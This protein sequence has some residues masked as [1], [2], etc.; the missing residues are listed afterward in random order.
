M[1]LQGLL[2]LTVVSFSTAVVMAQEVPDHA[3]T[4]EEIEWLGGKVKPDKASPSQAGISV[5]LCG[6]KTFD[7]NKVHL[8]KSIKNVTW[9]DLTD[10]GITD[11]GLKELKGLKNLAL[12]GLSDTM[13]TDA[14]SS[15]SQE[16]ASYSG[17]GS[18]GMVGLHCLVLRS[19]SAKAS[20]PL[21]RNGQVEVFHEVLH[22]CC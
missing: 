9:L 4:I 20:L 19:A 14:W 11:A 13:I 17:D 12:P 7:D 8:L 3:R 6:C 10:T 15:Q 16:V 22:S 5:S 21:A 18:A 2:L 1:H